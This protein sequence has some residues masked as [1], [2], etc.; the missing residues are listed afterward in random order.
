MLSFYLS[1]AISEEESS[2][3]E[4]IYHDH[5]RTMLLTALAILKDRD[6]A[7]D[8][9]QQAF[10][11]TIINLDRIKNKSDQKVLAYL[12]RTTQNIALNKI[13]DEGAHSQILYENYSDNLSVEPDFYKRLDRELLLNAVLALPPEARTLLELHI[14]HECSVADIARQT[15]AKPKTVQKRLE[16]A[17]NML[18]YSLQEKT[19]D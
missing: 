13:R 12:K 6:Q 19:D 15:N 3:I 7:E 9:V 17:R 16:R 5:R 10:L 11:N 8:T 2:L 18:I 1:L 14:Y 4:R